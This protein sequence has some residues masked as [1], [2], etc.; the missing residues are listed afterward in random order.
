MQSTPWLS[1]EKW[2]SKAYFVILHF[3]NQLDVSS[4]SNLFRS[5]FC[6]L[7]AINL[8]FSDWFK[9]QATVPGPALIPQLKWFQFPLKY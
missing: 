2:I 1:P 8:L 4:N 3:S 7:E 5:L 9:K 6:P